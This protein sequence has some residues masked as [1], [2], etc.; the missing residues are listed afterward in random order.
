MFIQVYLNENNVP[1]AKIDGNDYNSR[2]YT[3]IKEWLTCRP[4]KTSSNS[5]FF[6]SFSIHNL[7]IIFYDKHLKLH[8]K[9]IKGIIM[10]IYFHSYIL[11][12]KMYCGYQHIVK[13]PKYT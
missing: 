5:S 12:C 10:N 4:F 11:R 13:L 1:L 6:T 9:I 8:C 7:F 2:N 3:H